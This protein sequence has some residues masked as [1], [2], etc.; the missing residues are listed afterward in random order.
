MFLFS[1][2]RSCTLFINFIPTFLPCYWKWFL[3]Y[4]IFQ[5]FVAYIWKRQ[6]WYIA[7]VSW[8]CDKLFLTIFILHSF[9]RIFYTVY[10][11]HAATAAKLLQSCPTLCNAIDGSS[12]SSPVP[13]I[14][15]AR[16][17]EWVAISFSNAWKW[18][19]KVKS[20]SGVWLFSTPW[21]T[22]YQ[23][24]PFMGISRQGYWSGVPLP[25][26]FSS[27]T[28][29]YSFISPVLM[30]MLFIS[31]SFFMHWLWPPEQF[32]K[33]VLLS[34]FNSWKMMLWKRYTHMPANL[35]NSVVTTGLEKVHFHSNP[36]ER[37]CQRM[38]KLLHNCT[39]L[40]R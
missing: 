40:T 10:F 18:K 3:K 12:P 8:E 34:Y 38:L 33:E 4:F 17:L 30:H 2:R 7:F 5:F 21:T 22:A 27:L 9:L 25:S 32:W 13:G 15:Q 11:L 23:A 19:V 31:I 29:K 39:H 24:P 35:E 14:L 36:K 1:K 26:P 20:L 16:T 6:F 28:N 37:Q